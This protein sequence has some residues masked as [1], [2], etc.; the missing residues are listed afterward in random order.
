MPITPAPIPA[1]FYAP[2]VKQGCF[3]NDVM[4][5]VNALAAANDILV[6]AS[7]NAGLAFGSIGTA[8][9][10]VPSTAPA[11]TYLVTCYG[12]ITTALTGNSISGVAFVLGYTDDQGARTPTVATV[13]AV[14]AG[15]VLQ[16]SYTFRSNGTAAI[17]L[18]PNYL[19]GAPTSGNLGY[20]MMLQ[21]IL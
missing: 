3:D 21:R 4:S 15:T 17:T 13:S 11:G 7:Q 12:V 2:L 9:T 20:S 16:G 19:T 10:L 14:S 5:S 18:N 8:V 1:N 6:A